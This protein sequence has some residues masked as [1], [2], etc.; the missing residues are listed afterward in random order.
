MTGLQWL[1]LM[2]PVVDRNRDEGRP[3][4]RLHRHVIGPRDRRWHVFGARGLD[5]ELDI[6]P[7]KFRSALGIKERLQRQY[8]ARLLARG[9]H[10]RGLVAMG[11]EDIAKRVA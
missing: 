2:G 10:H 7:R 11:S 8:A 9:N 4:G 6:G 5:R 3:A 1:G